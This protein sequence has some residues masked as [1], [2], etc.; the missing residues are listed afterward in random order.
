M[1]NCKIRKNKKMNKK[2][3]RNKIIKRINLTYKVMK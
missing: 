2:D 3:N 1:R